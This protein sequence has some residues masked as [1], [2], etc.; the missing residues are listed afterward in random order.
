MDIY[1]NPVSQEVKYDET[2]L[3][4]R[5]RQND[6]IDYFNLAISTIAFTLSG[7]F[8]TRI[9][10]FLKFHEKK[11]FSTIVKPSSTSATVTSS[12]QSFILDAHRS[13]IIL[14]VNNSA[15]NINKEEK[16]TVSSLELTTNNLVQ[17]DSST[18]I[19]LESINKD[20]ISQKDI[21]KEVKLSRTELIKVDGEVFNVS[22]N[23][24]KGR[25][26][27]EI[28]TAKKT[29][30]IMLSFLSCQ[31]IFLL[32]IL[33]HKLPLFSQNG[34][35]V[36][37]FH[38]KFFTYTQLGIY[39]T[40]FSYLSCFLNSFTFILVTD[41]FKTEAIIYVSRFKRFLCHDLKNNINR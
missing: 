28:R 21:K 34:L 36:D 17:R 30:T 3:R 24:N 26:R 32:S 20:T 38:E 2:E 11:L 23:V 9:I 8:Y 5:N 33:I 29:F 19:S 22:S 31:L 39:L 37:Q 6:C 4:L 7:Y 12:S 27:L 10:L 15:S 1:Y 41:L 35:I 13:T 40:I 25:R 14:A 16:I 18:Q